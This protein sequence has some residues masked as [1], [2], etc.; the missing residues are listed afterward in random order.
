MDT[1]A[2]VSKALQEYECAG[3]FAPAIAAEAADAALEAPA[4]STESTANAPAPLLSSERRE[5]SLPQPAEA[6]E[7]TSTAATTGAVE[8]VVGEAG[9][10]LPRSV[11]TEPNEVRALDEP[12]AATQEQAVVEGTS[13]VASS[14]I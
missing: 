3:G 4:T 11:T 8:A 6:A 12:A 14:E 7:A 10:S 9:S 13:R 2:S 1:I 5:A